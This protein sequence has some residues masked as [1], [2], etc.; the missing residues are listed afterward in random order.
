MSLLVFF[1]LMMAR[2]H[3]PACVW[4]FFITYEMKVA[5]IIIIIV[6]SLITSCLPSVVQFLYKALYMHGY[7][8]LLV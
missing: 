7:V 1:S 4:S 3:D 8:F 5:A 6:V 2:Y